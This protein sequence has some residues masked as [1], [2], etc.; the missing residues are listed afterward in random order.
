MPRI[1]DISRILAAY[2][3]HLMLEKGL[4][5]NTRTSYRAD[6]TKLIVYLDGIA[7]PLREVTCDTL[8][9][10]VADLYDLGI[11]PRSQ[12]RIISGIKSFFRFLVTDGYLDVNPSLLLDAPNLG[13]HLPEVLT[14]AEIDAMEAA[15]DMS[16]NEGQRNKAIIE[17]LYGCGLRV[18]ELVNLEISKLFLDDEYLVVRGKGDKERLVP[19][20]GVAVDEIRRYLDERARLDI[21]PGEENILFLNRRGRR[22]T[23]VMIFYIIKRL[24]AL[25]GIRKDISPHTL[26]HSFATHLLEGGANLRAI[27]Q[28]LGHESIST[29]EIYI[30]IDRSRLREEILTH[31]P[32]NAGY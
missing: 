21:K 1:D 16:S 25:A 10:F 9:A 8:H 29:T 5:D 7:M 26:R 12:A 11:A 27:Q 14:I 15:I 4:S 18:S 24:A 19:M 20:S 2:D 23:R 31:H 28:M 32:R 22:L 13:R 17:T 3:A 6:V 30:H